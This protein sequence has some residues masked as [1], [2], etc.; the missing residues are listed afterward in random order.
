[1]SDDLRSGVPIMGEEKMRVTFRTILVSIGFAL[2]VYAVL[3]IVVL[4]NAMRQIVFINHDA[5][6]LMCD[7]ASLSVV[8]GTIALVVAQ[9]TNRKAPEIKAGTP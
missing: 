1:M 5:A 3:I 8:C 4:A 7:R 6:A 2:N 9:F